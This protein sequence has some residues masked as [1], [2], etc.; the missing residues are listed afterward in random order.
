MVR[1]CVFVVFASPC[2]HDL[3]FFGFCLQRF[4][5][6]CEILTRVAIVA[7]QGQK[8]VPSSFALLEHTV[9]L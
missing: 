3:W 6:E 9:Q 4:A 1:D 2:R 7:T 8:P 5:L